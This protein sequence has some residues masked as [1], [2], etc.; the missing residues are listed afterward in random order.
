[1]S[2][3]PTSPSTSSLTRRQPDALAPQKPAPSAS[4]LEKVGQALQNAAKGVTQHVNNVVDVFEAKLPSVPRPAG[5]KPWEG[6][7][8]TGNPLKIPLDALKKV[9]LGD[10]RKVLERLFPPKV[11]DE[12]GGT[13]DPQKEKEPWQ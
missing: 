2:V 13:E 3:K 9:D 4:P 10:V 12:Q 1:M 5:T 11:H 8:L 6:I 7:T